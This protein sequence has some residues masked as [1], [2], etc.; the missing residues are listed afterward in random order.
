MCTFVNKLGKIIELYSTMN[1]YLMHKVKN[2][3]QNNHSVILNE[4]LHTL[5]CQTLKQPTDM[6]YSIFLPLAYKTIFSTTP[7]HKLIC[8]H[9]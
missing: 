6:L 7:L 2:K 9:K 3:Y 8:P 1:I 4:T 5:I